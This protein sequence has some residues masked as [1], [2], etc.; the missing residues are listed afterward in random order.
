MTD[1]FAVDAEI[2]IPD[3]LPVKFNGEVV[4]RATQDPEDPTRVLVHVDADSALGRHVGGRMEGSADIGGLSLYSGN[5][6]DIESIDIVQKPPV[7]TMKI[8]DPSGELGRALKEMF[9]D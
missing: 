3:N 8:E 5:G 7:A 1:Q 9:N 6:T 2:T 4:G